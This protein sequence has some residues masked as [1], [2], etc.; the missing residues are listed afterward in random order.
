[1]HCF[2]HSTYALQIN[3]E[4]GFL[5]EALSENEWFV[6]VMK[7][8]YISSVSCLSDCCFSAYGFWDGVHHLSACEQMF[9]RQPNWS[10]GWIEQQYQCWRAAFTN[11]ISLLFW[12]LHSPLISSHKLPSRKL[13]EERKTWF[14]VCLCVCVWVCRQVWFYLEKH[15]S[16]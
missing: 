14:R 16:V 1:M 8:V 15:C 9:Q 3:T 11:Y 10:Q 12:P 6:F 2:G 4:L 5:L 7:G 13:K